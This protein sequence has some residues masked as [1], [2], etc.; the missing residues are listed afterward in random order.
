MGVQQSPAR[1]QR[2]ATT[3]GMV[4]FEEQSDLPPL[5]PV[6]TKENARNIQ[7]PNNPHVRPIYQASGMIAQQ[8]E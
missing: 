8:N 6:G 4:Y 5:Y 2:Q 7:H 1:K 3:V